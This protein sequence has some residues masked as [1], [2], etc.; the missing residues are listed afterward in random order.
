MQQVSAAGR[1]TFFIDYPVAIPEGIS[2]YYC[3]SIDEERDVVTY[4]AIESG[5]VI[6]ANTPFFVEGN[7]GYYVYSADNSGTEATITNNIMTGSTT[8]TTVGKHTVLTLGK[9]DQSGRYGFWWF[10]GTSIG[11]YRSW[12]D[13]SYATAS[14]NAKG[15]TLVFDDGGKS[16]ATGI[17]DILQKR[18]NTNAPI[19][20]LHGQRVKHISRG[21]II[22]NGRK[23]I[24]E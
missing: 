16:E 14:N 8:P 12:I 19:Y 24:V 4:A 1:A 6:P 23:Q 5:Q 10:T 13:G 11:A 18:D 9:S 7:P 3:N 15:Y 22:R 21:I 2:A 17:T 20:N